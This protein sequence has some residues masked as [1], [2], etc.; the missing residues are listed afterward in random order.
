MYGGSGTYRARWLQELSVPVRLRPAIGVEASRR[1]N[2][3]RVSVTTYDILQDLHGRAVVLQRL[4]S[5]RWSTVARARLVVA[6]VTG[7]FVRYA[8]R[9]RSATRGAILRV[10][11]PA[12]SAA[13]CFR[14]A[15]TAR[16]RS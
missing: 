7:G 8:A 5:G 16:L 14:A 10:H 13:P 3:I 1:S 6:P 12:T 4:R 9:F 15:T 11:V 2:H